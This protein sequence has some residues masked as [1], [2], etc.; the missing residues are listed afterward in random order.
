[1]LILVE[2]AD[3][4]FDAEK[5]A[6]GSWMFVVTE[7]IVKERCRAD[8]HVLCDDPQYRVPLT[9]LKHVRGF[10]LN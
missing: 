9:I 1:M 7:V 5:S 6:R 10:P 8:Y 4:G 3:N 2:L